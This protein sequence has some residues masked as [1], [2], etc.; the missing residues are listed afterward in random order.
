MLT[1]SARVTSGG[2][3]R[4]CPLNSP[5]KF[6]QLDPRAR[7]VLVLI[8]LWGDAT[9]CFSK[10]PSQDSTILFSHPFLCSKRANQ[11]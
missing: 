11:S 10:N 8:L 4:E 1:P 6:F 5:L 2:W 9:T 7:A 3:A